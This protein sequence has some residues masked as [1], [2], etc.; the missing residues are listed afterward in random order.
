MSTAI[1]AGRVLNHVPDSWKTIQA[2]RP[3]AKLLA[4]ADAVPEPLP[5]VARPHVLSILDQGQI[6]SCT[7][8]GTAQAIRAAQ[9]LAGVAAPTLASRLWLYWLGRC[10]DHDTA[11]DDGAQIGNVFLGGETY[12]LTPETVWPYDTSTFKGPPAPEA[13]RAAYDAIA[14]FRAHRINS[15]GDNL[16]ADV[17]EAL[18]QGRLVVFGSAVS[19]EYCSN[20]FDATVPLAPPS[21][22][23][24]AGLHCQCIGDFSADGAGFDVV[25]SWSE[26]WGNAGWSRYSPAYLTD[27]NSSDFWV[28]DATP[29]SPLVDPPAGGAS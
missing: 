12:G 11:N 24:I 6:G 9:H 10:Y 4:R 26:G 23:D 1:V 29:A 15:Q 20:A 7:G 22:G 25:N 2:A 28:V 8:N 3:A 18:G 27:Q 17:R 16:L 14:A 13:W 19:N 21:G 5:G